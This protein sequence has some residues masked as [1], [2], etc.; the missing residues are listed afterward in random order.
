MDAFF[1]ERER[2]FNRRKEEALKL[3]PRFFYKELYSLVKKHK[4]VGIYG[5]RGSG[6][7]T[8]VL[9]VAS[10]FKDSYY[11]S[12]DSLVLRG[13]RLYDFLAYLES[14][15]YKKI[16]IDE[17]HSYPD[18]SKELK[19]AYDDFDISI[20]FTGS[21]KLAIESKSEMLRRSVLF[22]L[23]PLSFREYLY[24][25]RGVVLP[26]A[27][28]DLII[29]EKERKK[30]LL[31]VQPYASLVSEFISF[32]GLPIGLSKERSLFLGVVKKIIDDDIPAVRKVDN[33]F[34]SSVYK[35]LKVITTSSPGGIS[36][37]TLASVCGRHSDT[38]EDIISLLEGAGLIKVIS[39]WARGPKLVRKEK[40]ITMVLPFR[41]VLSNTYSVIPD[42]GALREDFFTHH[43]EKV[44]YYP[45]GSRKSPDYVIDNTVFEI[46]GGS[47][48]FSQLKRKGYLV[49]DEMV[50]EK[51]KLPLVL[52]G[53]LY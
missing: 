5:L 33:A 48:G 8:L 37:R 39:P 46:G 17:I 14:K 35:I 41:S 7:T 11:F 12:C 53:L 18:W 26:K 2:I 6:K 45:T 20:V 10:K 52:F 32:G 25:S 24:L 1:I 22:H 28:L 27:T 19:I 3:K 16:F 44:Y 15:G 34:K 38:I 13:I 9:Q 51:N 21:S 29:D 36:I 49:T 43:F 50:L 4:S 47:K 23:P 42:K 30:L 31:E 40:K